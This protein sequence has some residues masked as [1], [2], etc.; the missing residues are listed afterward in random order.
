MQTET[1]IEVLDSLKYLNRLNKHDFS[2]LLFIDSLPYYQE[3]KWVSFK[4]NPLAFLW[5]CS[6]DKI[7]LISLYIKACQG[8]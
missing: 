1:I 6:E 8:E 7:N 4:N 5:S 2:N 3:E